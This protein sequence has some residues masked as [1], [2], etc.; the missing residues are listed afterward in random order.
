ML[1]SPDGQ[2]LNLAR[3]DFAKYSQKQALSKPLFEYIFYHEND[4][5]NAL[6]L[7]ALATE[8]AQFKDWW[9]KIQLGKTYYRYFKWLIFFSFKFKF[10]IFICL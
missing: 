7:A 1:S 4:M 5:R 2:F 9:W 10:T 6:Q 8:H 3:L